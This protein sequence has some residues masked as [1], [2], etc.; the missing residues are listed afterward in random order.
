MPSAVRSGAGGRGVSSEIAKDKPEPEELSS[1]IGNKCWLFSLCIDIRV[2]NGELRLMRREPFPA[3]YLFYQHWQTNWNRSPACFTCSCS[4]QRSWTRSIKGNGG[5]SAET[6]CCCYSF[7]NEL[8]QLQFQPSGVK[9][10]SDYFYSNC[11]I[12]TLVEPSCSVCIW[13]NL[14]WFFS[15]SVWA[16]ILKVFLINWIS[17]I[18]IHVLYISIIF[19]PPWVYLSSTISLLPLA[20]PHSS[21]WWKDQYQNG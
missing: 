2:S 18:V 4:L 3:L 16:F 12:F 6:F 7:F 17:G 9:L 20:A 10:R 14:Y 5:F 1:L 19:F 21:S 15:L 11:D 8:T 13:S